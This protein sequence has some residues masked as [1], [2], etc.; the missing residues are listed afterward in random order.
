MSEKVSSYFNKK[1]TAADKRKAALE[2]REELL[3]KL[4]IK[5]VNNR[6]FLLLCR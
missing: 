5:S 2:K 4:N 1:E 6:I 3:K